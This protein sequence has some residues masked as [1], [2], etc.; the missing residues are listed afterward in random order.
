MA[1]LEGQIIDTLLE[2]L[3]EWRSDLSYPE[4]YSDMEAC[5][6]ALLQMFKVERSPKPIPLR[7]PCDDCYASGYSKI[8]AEAC[9]VTTCPTCK[10]RRWVEL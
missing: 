6:R 4:S 5:V 10:G 3:S 2:G 9:S 1:T 8:D 7:Y